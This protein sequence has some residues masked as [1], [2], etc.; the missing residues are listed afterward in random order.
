MSRSDRSYRVCST[1]IEAIADAGIDGRSRPEGNRSSNSLSS[2]D[3]GDGQT[4]TRTYCPQPPDDRQEPASKRSRST[5]STPCTSRFPNSARYSAP[6]SPIVQRPPSATTV[7]CLVA[8]RFP[9][10]SSIATSMN[11]IRRPPHRAARSV[12]CANAG[13]GTGS[14]KLRVRVS[15]R[16]HSC[17]SPA[18]HMFGRCYNETP[19]RTPSGFGESGASSS[20][21]IAGYA[22]TDTHSA[23]R[24][25]TTR[26]RP[27]HGSGFGRDRDI[28]TGTARCFDIPTNAGLVTLLTQS[29]LLR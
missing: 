15:R 14:P 19:F 3:P 2:T 24:A 13:S 16:L 26:A 20:T 7:P 1:R 8:Q 12:I 9:W 4:R 17:A 22:S 21:N 23:P 11:L 28:Q 27:G 25:R 29:V 18:H 5:R 6:G 10:R